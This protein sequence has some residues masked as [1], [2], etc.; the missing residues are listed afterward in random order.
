MNYLILT[1]QNVCEMG[2]RVITI[3]LQMKKPRHRKIVTGPKAQPKNGEVRVQLQNP[4][5]LIVV[6]MK[7]CKA[8]RRELESHLLLTTAL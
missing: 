1:S 7:G 4:S 6:N 5:A 3:I 2:A 8:E